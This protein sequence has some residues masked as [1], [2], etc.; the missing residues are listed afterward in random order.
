MKVARISGTENYADEA[1]ELL[2]RYES[3]SFGPRPNSRV[4]SRQICKRSFEQDVLLVPPRG[5]DATP[6]FAL[7]Q[8]Q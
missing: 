2:K 5:V 4:I 6:D 7:A 3:I 1:P 8:E